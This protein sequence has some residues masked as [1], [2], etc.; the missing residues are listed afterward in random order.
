MIGDKVKLENINYMKKDDFMKKIL[1]ILIT[2][3]ILFSVTGCGNNTELEALKK[4][5][6]ELKQQLKESNKSETTSPTSTPS[7]K[8]TYFKAEWVDDGSPFTSSSDGAKL[9]ISKDILTLYDNGKGYI[10]IDLTYTN[11]LPK[12]RSFINDGSASIVAFQ[13]GVEIK[14]ITTTVEDSES[15]FTLLKDGASIQTLRAFE[16][17]DIE[18]EI[19]VEIGD[20]SN[21]DKKIF[22]KIKLSK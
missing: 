19:E 17:N 10:R 7:P 12:S 16:L 3:V 5:N 9:D 1:T 4:E 8:K 21:Y 6:E 14:D 13:N 20:Y 18:S 11:N 22:K 15:C 2:S